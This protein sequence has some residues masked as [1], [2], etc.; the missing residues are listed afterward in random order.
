MNDLAPTLSRKIVF[1]SKYNLPLC[2]I[3]I[4]YILYIDIDTV[5][6]HN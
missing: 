1:E 4:Y 5:D 3:D 2:V 6:I